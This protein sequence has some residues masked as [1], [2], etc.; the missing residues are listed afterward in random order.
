M[1]SKKLPAK[2][3]GGSLAHGAGVLAAAASNEYIRVDYLL[4]EVNWYSGR[5]AFFSG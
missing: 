3:Y 1:R 2:G 4:E 5:S